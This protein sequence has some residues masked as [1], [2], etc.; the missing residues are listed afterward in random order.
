MINKKGAAL[1]T[2]YMVVAVLMAFGGFVIDV[3][4]SQNKTASTF[5]RQAQVINI[6]EAG[7]DR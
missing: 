4:N 2:V 6:A 3:S 7:L 1:I 5:K